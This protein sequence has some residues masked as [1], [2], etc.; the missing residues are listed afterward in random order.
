MSESNGAVGSGLWYENGKKKSRVV[1][2]VK[3]MTQGEARQTVTG[4]VTANRAKYETSSTPK[5]G[6]F[7]TGIFSLTTAGNGRNPRAETT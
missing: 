5:F 3:D 6:E 1:G 7:V 2:L 4:I